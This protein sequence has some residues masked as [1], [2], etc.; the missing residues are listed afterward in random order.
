MTNEIL[1]TL[2]TAASGITTTVIAGY[3]N[4]L[5]TKRVHAENKRLKIELSC[6]SIVFDH[7]LLQVLEDE[8]SVMF[9]DTKADRFIMFFA[10]NGTTELSYITAW[11]DKRVPGHYTSQYKYVRFE[12]DS[13]YKDILKEVERDGTVTIDVS[14]MNP[15]VLRDV[16]TSTGE[17]VNHCILKFLKRTRIDDQNDLVLYSTIATNSKEPFTDQEKI[18][19]KTCY[20]AIRAE[21]HK[22]TFTTK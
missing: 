17:M 21:S 11:F 20:D 22:L 14:K 5:K 19:L 9:R 2:I 18:A 12:I 4:I 3:Y 7:N 1:I 8:V 6:L 10:V 13:Y 15:S 16:Y